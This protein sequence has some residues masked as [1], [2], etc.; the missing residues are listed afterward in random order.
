MTR[1][2]LHIGGLMPAEL[3][4]LETD[5]RVIRLGRENDP[6]GI[7]QQYRNDIVGIVTSFTRRV[8]R[9]LIEALPNLEIICQ[10]GVGVDNID[11]EAARERQI[12]VT[13][14]PDLVTN[15]TAD[16]AMAL[17]LSCARRV[18]EG[19]AYV[20]V[21]KWANG[22]MPLGVSLSGKT[23][24]IV[25]LGRIGQAVVRRAAAF[26]MKIAYY[27]RQE[28]PEFSYSYYPDLGKLAKDSDFMILTV[29]GGAETRHLV[30][31]DILKALGP[32][33]YLINVARGSV[34]DQEA[35]LVALRNQ[36]IAGV[37]LDVFENEPQVPEALFTM[38]NVVLLPH[39][40]T[41][42]VETRTKMG[43][44]VLK[45]L[46]AYFSGEPLMTPVAA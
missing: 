37:G 2:I 24:G 46:H 17:L 8:N 31:A 26:D 30:N 21:G 19:D 25:G 22:P 4:Q 3:A 27:G 16:I 18:V 36:D 29:S 10:F 45:N 7:L 41:A 23:A 6:E 5:Y 20:R 14:T 11:L 1:T 12:V 34:V 38:D 35:L 32:E 43:R 15:D 39:V 40:G 13:N 9:Q 42:T 28:K 33:G 44:L